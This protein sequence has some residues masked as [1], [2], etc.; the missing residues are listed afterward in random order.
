MSGTNNHIH[1][2]KHYCLFCENPDYHSLIRK[3]TKVKKIMLVIKLWDSLPVLYI[4][5]AA[6]AIVK[7]VIIIIDSEIAYMQIIVTTF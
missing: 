6:K 5:Q 3:Y 7:I 2:I 1:K 4:I